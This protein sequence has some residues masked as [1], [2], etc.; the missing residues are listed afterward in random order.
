MPT[1]AFLSCEIQAGYFLSLCLSRRNDARYYTLLWELNELF[2]EHAY[3]VAD[4][5]QV[6]TKYEPLP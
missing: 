1:A 2:I 4:K 5:E 3:T 6:F